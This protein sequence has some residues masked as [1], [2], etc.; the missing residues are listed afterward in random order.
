MDKPSITLSTIYEALNGAA[1]VGR[2]LGISTEHAAG[3]RRRRSIPPRYWAELLTALTDKGVQATE[4]DLVRIYNDPA[5]DMPNGWGGA[6]CDQAFSDA[7][8][9]C[10]KR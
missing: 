8:V 7:E 4:A 2:A 10:A 5:K 3:L 1:E 6:E 9:G